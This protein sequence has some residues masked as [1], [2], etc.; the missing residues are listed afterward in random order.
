MKFKNK[1]LSRSQRKK[2]LDQLVPVFPINPFPPVPPPIPQNNCL[3]FVSNFFS[4]TISVFSTSPLENIDTITIGTPFF[5]TPSGI[6]Y[7][8]NNQRVYALDETDAELF[9]INPFTRQIEETIQLSQALPT[10][11]IFN[12]EKDELYMA[13]LSQNSVTVFDT[14]T[15]TETLIVPNIPRATD[16]AYINNGA[17]TKLY[18]SN[19]G[20]N[21]PPVTNTVS[22]IDLGTSPP[23]VGSIQ[24]GNLPVGVLYNPNV[25]RVFVANQQS[26]NF[27]VIDPNT[28]TVVATIQT[29]GLSP[30]LTD[31]NP[32]TNLLY[33][34]NQSSNPD[35]TFEVTV[36]D[37]VTNQVVTTIPGLLGNGR[38]VSI[39]PVRNIIYVSSAAIG[40]RDGYLTA[41]NG[42]TNEIIDSDMF[43]GF[44]PSHLVFVPVCTA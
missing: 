20:Q 9:I 5:D 28:D 25:G 37:M 13:N 12:P 1:C 43:P 26:Q 8:P 44:D 15:N 21:P 30:N 6:I 41:I 42:Q 29:P 34:A 4:G 17:D 18:V 7:N 14:I 32:N 23:T 11:L 33:A 27:S 35:G 39:D 19:Y 22:T 10:Q 2:L 16:I 36:I 3:V 24:V 31:F 38:D 40:S